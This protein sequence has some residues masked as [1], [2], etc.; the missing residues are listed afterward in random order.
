MGR[1]GNYTRPVR[2][3]PDDLTVRGGDIVGS[4][5]NEDTKVSL[6]ESR[7]Q[8]VVDGAVKVDAQPDSVKLDTGAG[9]GLSVDAAGKT[10]LARPFRSVSASDSPVALTAA[11]G[12]ITCDTAAGPITLVAPSPAT[13]PTGQFIKIFDLGSAGTNAITVDCVGFNIG[14]SA[15]Y[16]INSDREMAEISSTG[17]E[18]IVS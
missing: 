10:T 1:R 12:V 15:T 2:I 6:I 7:A 13:F 5:S 17:S 14:G 9:P 11:D 4:D 3:A 8:L 16:L 18:W